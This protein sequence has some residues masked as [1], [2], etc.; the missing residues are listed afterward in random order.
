MLTVLLMQRGTY[1]TVTLIP[2]LIPADLISGESTQLKDDFRLQFLSYGIPPKKG[3]PHDKTR[4]WQDAGKPVLSLEPADIIPTTRM[5]KK[6]WDQLGDSSYREL[7]Q[8]I[9]LGKAL[10]AGDIDHADQLYGE[11]TLR[12][13]QD[14]FSLNWKD[15][16][17]LEPNEEKRRA[18]VIAGLVT[19]KLKE[20]RIVLWWNGSWLVPAI[21]CADLW[22]AVYTL[23]LRIFAGG[24]AAAVCPH[25]QQLFVPSRPDQDYCTIAHREAHRVARWRARKKV[26]MSKSKGGSNVTREKR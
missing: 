5:G 11:I 18:T 3:V 1:K 6:I 17:L 22:T 13:F 24:N 25:C 12:A 9:M 20:A 2:I 15:R 14:D 7:I 19:Y 21:W 16:T 4:K 26:K 8:L 23:S 10:K